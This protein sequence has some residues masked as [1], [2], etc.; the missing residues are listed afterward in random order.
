MGAVVALAP[1]AAAA[2]RPSLPMRLALGWLH[3]G[4]LFMSGP[5]KPTAQVGTW[6]SREKDEAAV[7]DQTIVALERRGFCQVTSYEGASLTRWCALLTAAGE[8]AYAK[9]GGLHVGVPRVPLP[10]QAAIERFDE[11]L[12]AISE[13]LAALSTVAARIGPRIQQ[14]RDE[15]SLAI[16]DNER[17]TARIA[18]LTRLA[19]GL[20]GHRDAMRALLTERRR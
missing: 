16:R 8:E 4:P 14:A 19:G 9:I 17:T 7:A 13:E 18:E 12:A 5:R 6:R 2:E 15:I 10:A 11:A 3:F 20:G 1:A